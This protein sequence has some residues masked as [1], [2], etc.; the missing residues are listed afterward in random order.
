MPRHGSRKLYIAPMCSGATVAQE[1]EV[2]RHQFRL[3]LPFVLSPTTR[4]F[5]R[6]RTKITATSFRP[7][8][9]FECWSQADFLTFLDSSCFLDLVWCRAHS[10]TAHFPHQNLRTL[11]TCGCEYT[12]AFR[13]RSAR[14]SAA[15]LRMCYRCRHVV[16]DYNR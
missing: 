2:R 4:C 8:I 12:A 3:M 11:S 6:G 7:A 10:V 9:L 14:Q 1:K 15:Y 5:P 16:S 13:A